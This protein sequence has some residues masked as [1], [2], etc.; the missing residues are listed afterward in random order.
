MGEGL[1]LPSAAAEQPPAEEQPP[2]EELFDKAPKEIDMAEKGPENTF[3]EKQK[4]AIDGIAKFEVLKKV[5]LEV[6]KA[7]AKI[8]VGLGAAMATLCGAWGMMAPHNEWAIAMAS[9]ALA[10][11]AIRSLYVAGRNVDRA[12]PEEK[13]NP[14][15][16]TD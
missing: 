15:E 1:R 4:E 10:G 2:T 16:N 11:I 8:G 5:A 6:T 7:G 12:F 3:A 14:W 9:A 13:E